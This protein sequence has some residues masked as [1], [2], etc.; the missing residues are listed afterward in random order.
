MVVTNVLNSELEQ[1]KGIKQ[2]LRIIKINGVDVHEHVATNIKPFIGSSTKQWL[3]LLAYGR[4]ATRGRRSESVHLTFKD[5]NNQVFESAISRSLPENNL[6]RSLFEFSI[7]ENNIGLL[8][9]NSFWHENFT[10]YFDSIYEKI[11][12]TDA[13]IIDIRMNSGGNSLNS[14][15][16]LSH[17]TNESFRMAEWSSLRYIPAFVSWNRP[18]EWYVGAP[19]Y[20]QPIQNKPIYDR[21]VAVIIDEST[22]S[23]AEDFCVGFRNMNRGLI[24]GTPSAGS[25]GN[26]VFFELPGGGSV[27]I[28]AIKNTFPDGTEFVGIGIL[29]DIEVRETVSS[30]FSRT[31]SGADNTN[32]V[33]KA[34]EV[35]KNSMRNK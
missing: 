26:S 5:E 33:R 15:Y 24:I 2:G 4:N 10:T 13:L 20:I 17:L 31:E 1:K 11:L 23:A 3:N 35:L 19:R 34:V 32:A 28:C 27:Q 6:E 14:E 22:F 8:R 21:P 12:T 30:F 29:P 18:V 7:L 25:T 16:V 9:I